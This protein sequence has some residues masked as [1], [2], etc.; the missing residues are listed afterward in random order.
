MRI[1]PL[2]LKNRLIMRSVG[3]SLRNGSTLGVE[4]V[5]VEPGMVRLVNPLSARRSA[6]DHFLSKKKSKTVEISGKG[7][8]I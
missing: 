3:F 5:G 6:L 1:V 2:A 8:P 4:G 7:G